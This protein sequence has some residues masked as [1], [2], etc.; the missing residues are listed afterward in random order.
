MKEIDKKIMDIEL[1]FKDTLENDKK[2]QTNTETE[3]K[4]VIYVG[5][6]K[7][8]DRINS[9]PVKEKLFIVTKDVLIKN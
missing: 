3:I 6:A 7:W 8:I 1:D 4:D 2:Q 9:N 5:E